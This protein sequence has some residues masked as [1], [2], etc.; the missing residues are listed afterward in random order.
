M[1]YVKKWLE[2]TR[3][4]KAFWEV[5]CVDIV[6][7]ISRSSILLVYDIDSRPFNFCWCTIVLCQKSVHTH[8][9]FLFLFT[10]IYLYNA[11]SQCLAV[12][13]AT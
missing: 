2:H 1:T 6:D 3:R 12:A 13:L 8:P 4:G 10:T 11:I 7:Y 5:W 9:Y